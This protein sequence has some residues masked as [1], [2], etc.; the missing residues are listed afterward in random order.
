MT[1]GRIHDVNDVMIGW[2]AWYGDGKIFTS[3]LNK[4][5][6]IPVENFQYLKV[7]YDRNTDVFAGT[8]LYCIT[9]HHD[10]I[11]KLIEED[12]RNIKIGKAMDRKEFDKLVQI[13]EADKEKITVMI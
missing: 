4:W 9:Q 1:K 6:D 10:E 8:D 2:K 12:P 13:V 5:V 7:F 11:K 3:I